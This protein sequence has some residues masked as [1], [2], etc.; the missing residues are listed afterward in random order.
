LNRTTKNSEGIENYISQVEAAR[1]RGVSPQAIANLIRR[2]RLSAVN[3]VG[4]T[5]V[6]RSE[7]ESFVPRHQGRP[8]KEISARMGNIKKPPEVIER[9]TPGRY[10]SQ[11]EAARIRGIS[12]EAIADL[13]RR[14]RLT[15]VVVG[16][17]TLL[18]R[19]EVE[20]FVAKPNLGRPS[21]KK[22]GMQK[23]PTRKSKK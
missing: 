4:R 2:G 21:G 6:L 5:L 23:P 17:R 1:I 7:V 10:I 14:S 16:G 13:I 11:A 22:S 15:T 3:I 12:Q 9:K 8:S 18:L 19:S 20:A